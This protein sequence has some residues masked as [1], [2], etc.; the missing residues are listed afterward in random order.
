MAMFCPLEA[1]DILWPLTDGCRE[2]FDFTLLFEECFFQII[3]SALLLLSTPPRAVHLF[4]QHARISRT[5]MRSVKQCCIVLLSCTQLAMLVTW[6]LEPVYRTHASIPAAA[7]SIIASL[8]LLFLSSIEHVRSIKPSTI[9]NTY[10][11]FSV[12]LDTAQ[13]RTLWLRPGPRILPAIFTASFVAK[14]ACLFLEARSKRG[15]LSLPDLMSA[16]EMLV[17]LYDRT[18]LLWLNPLFRLGFKDSIPSQGLFPIDSDLASDGLDRK[19]QDIWTHYKGTSEHDLMW[20]LVVQNRATIVSFMIPRLFLSAFKLLQPLLIDEVTTLIA[21][22]V[23]EESTNAGRGLIG[24]TFF[25][26]AGLAI[27]NALYR[28]QVQRFLVMLRG[29]LVTAL[30]RK[31]LITPSESLNDNAAITL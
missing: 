6:S 10:V 27:S 22:K 15:L 29:T 23:K 25:V 21:G 31:L 4:R 5:G 13:L 12:L 9:I 8:A 26:Y 11:F 17:S 19:F 24:A 16:P 18:I 14:T 2:N 20:A 30:Y 7:L 1:D 28:R 3:P